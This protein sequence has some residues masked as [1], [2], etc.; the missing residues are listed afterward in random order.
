MKLDQ[1]WHRHRC[2]KI[3]MMSSLSNLYNAMYNLYIALLCVSPAML[4]LV[5]VHG[6]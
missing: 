3:M 2:V 1:V 4:G 5:V 6:R